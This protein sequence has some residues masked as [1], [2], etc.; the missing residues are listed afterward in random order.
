MVFVDVFQL[1]C[2]IL[3]LNNLYYRRNKKTLH[4]I[5]LAMHIENFGLVKFVSLIGKYGFDN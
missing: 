5:F 3:R 1:Q 2:S 4:V